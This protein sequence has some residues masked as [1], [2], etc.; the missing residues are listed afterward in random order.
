MTNT[1]AVLAEI[2]R[3]RR[4]EAKA[5]KVPWETGSHVCAEEVYPKKGAPVYYTDIYHCGRSV[6]LT[7]DERNSPGSANSEEAI[8]ARNSHET[9]L[10]VE[11]GRASC[12]GRV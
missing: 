1:Q 10:A 9:L 3:H 8:L 11:I 4:I 12:R 6:N 5:T 7:G 2:A